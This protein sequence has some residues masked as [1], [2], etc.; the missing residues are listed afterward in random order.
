[1][2]KSKIVESETRNFAG[3]ENPNIVKKKLTLGNLIEKEFGNGN[4]GGK[5]VQNRNFA[6]KKQ[7]ELEISRKKKS[8]VQVLFRTRKIPF[9]EQTLHRSLIND[10]LPRLNSIREKNYIAVSYPRH[11][12]K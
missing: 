12:L 9:L 7:L 2:T 5:T 6:D 10:R 4:L 8:L 3:K 11:Q 1:M